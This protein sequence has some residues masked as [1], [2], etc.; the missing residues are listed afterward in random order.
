MAER[1]Q[2]ILHQAQHD[3]LTGLANRNR[4]QMLISEAL[5][6]RPTQP[7]TLCL[8]DIVRFSDINAF[9]GHNLGDRLVIEVA[10][11]LTSVAPH[12]AQVARV[13]VDQF[14][15]VL[16]ECALDSGLLLGTDLLRC[17]RETIE[18]DG[19][20]LH[21]LARG[22]LAEYPS[23]GT[24][25]EDLMRR[26]DVALFS[27]H[28][29]A[30]DIAVF[31][32]AVEAAHRRRIEVLGELQH[33]IESGQLRLVYQPKLDLQTRTL[34]NCEVLVRW[35]HPVYGDVP[36]SEFIPHAERTGSIRHL[37][38]WVLQTVATQLNIWN[39]TG[40]EPEIAIN[41]SAAD[42]VDPDLPAEVE[43]LLAAYKIPGRQLI[44]EITESVA[45]RN[46]DVALR[47]MERLKTLGIRFAIDD[48][49]T[50]YSSLAQLSRLPVDEL[51]LDSGLIAR[52]AEDERAHVVIGAMVKLGHT[53]NMRIVAE[54]V[55]NAQLMRSIA[56]LG[57][58]VAQGYAI[59]KPLPPAGFI[60]WLETHHLP[61]AA[62]FESTQVLAALVR[63][64]TANG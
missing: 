1:E 36:P 16:P 20:P 19:I 38:S 55:E 50:G 4:I 49:G 54:G 35:R 9:F 32:P 52:L 58:D 64:L 42:I 27:A 53:L 17:L 14:L 40:I 41:L 34:T 59:A 43:R 29:D 47:A 22:G 10:K 63:D 31:E 56:K 39:A 33:G 48:F 13:G 51:K 6:S 61:Q 60:K 18:A 37:T 5:V 3:E 25:A 11:R 21:L 45:M 44:F 15:I 7:F 26:V 23:H 62:N 30:S 8:I 2:R 28:K 24:T 46:I 57:C 12:Q